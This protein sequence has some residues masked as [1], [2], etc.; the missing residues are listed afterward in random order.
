MHKNVSLGMHFN[1][2]WVILC[3]MEWSGVTVNNKW[4]FTY[5]TNTVV[6]S[7]VWKMP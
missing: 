1:I 3:E 5:L 2:E 7:G 6:D 4:A